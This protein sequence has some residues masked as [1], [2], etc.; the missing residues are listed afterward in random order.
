MRKIFC[1]VQS[2]KNDFVCLPILENIPI[3]HLTVKRFQKKSPV[4]VCVALSK[5]GILPMKSIHKKAKINLEHYILDIPATHL[6]AQ[7]AKFN[8]KTKWIFQQDFVPLHR[9]KST[10]VWHHVSCEVDHGRNLTTSFT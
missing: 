10:Q 2:Y 3:N 4:I 9:V 5:N 1:S 7:T 6:L 8:S